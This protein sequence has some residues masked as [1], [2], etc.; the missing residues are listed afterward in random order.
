MEKSK[1]KPASDEVQEQHPTVY[2]IA[3]PNGVGKTTF[4]GSM[5]P[6]ENRGHVHEN[7]NWQTY[8]RPRRCFITDKL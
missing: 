2:V 3:G 1:G 6:G 8:T 4:E 7:V 5:A